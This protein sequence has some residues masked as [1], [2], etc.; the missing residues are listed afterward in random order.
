MAKRQTKTLLITG[1]ASGIGAA[2]ARLAAARGHQVAIAD[3]NAAGAQAV[4]AEIGPAARA[5]ALDI[6]KPEQWRAAIEATVAAFGGLDVLINN[7][8]IVHTGRAENI[9]LAQHQQTMDV[10]F[11]GPLTG[12]LETLPRFKAQGHGHFVTVC[13]MTAFLP[14]PGLASY[15]AAKHALRAFHH[16]FAIEQRD[17]PFAFTIIHPT[18]T[19][20]PMLDQEAE[21]DEAPLC[22]SSPSVSA[23]F[24][25]GVVLDA[26]KRKSLEIFMPPERARTVRMLGTNPRGLKK[27]VVQGEAVGA[28][29]LAARRAARGEA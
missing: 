5:V 13:S 20:T 14:F 6:T 18:S 25:A 27:L 19:E 17:S 26:M 3:I 11:M 10:N 16:A 15:A 28:G 2:T 9:G 29:R 7:A 12:M 21:S 1:G 8:A 22:F 24:V 23:E 4:A